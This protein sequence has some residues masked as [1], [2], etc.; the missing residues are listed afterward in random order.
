M[1]KND[2]FII[3]QCGNLI[4]LKVYNG[5]GSLL[6]KL[7][8]S[9]LILAFI[10]LSAF[11]AKSSFECFFGARVTTEFRNSMDRYWVRQLQMALKKGIKNSEGKAHCRWSRMANDSIDFG[12]CTSRPVII[13]DNLDGGEKALR[14]TTHA[15]ASLPCFMRLSDSVIP[16]ANKGIFTDVFLPGGT[17][18]GPYEGFIKSIDSKG[19]DPELSWYAWKIDISNPENNVTHFYSD[20]DDEVFSNWLRW[21]N[22]A[23][24][25]YGQEYAKYLGISALPDSSYDWST[26]FAPPKSAVVCPSCHWSAGFANTSFKGTYIDHDDS[27]DTNDEDKLSIFE[28]KP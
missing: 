6:I 4:E 5:F 9:H 11:L 13:L 8:K 17:L 22:A 10:C 24:F 27:D 1:K 28:A 21:I 25:W 19:E 20:A 3:F 7:A 15:K 26:D 2:A 12:E 23:R 14:S 16:G 18:F